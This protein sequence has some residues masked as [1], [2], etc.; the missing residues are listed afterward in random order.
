MPQVWDD[1]R[2]VI[3][4]RGLSAVVMVATAV[5]LLVAPDV[6][7]ELPRPSVDVVAGRLN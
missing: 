4:F 1:P 2:G 5:G 3:R 6:F 7:K